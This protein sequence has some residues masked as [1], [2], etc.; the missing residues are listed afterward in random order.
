MFELNGTCYPLSLLSGSL[1]STSFVSFSSSF[2][3][4]LRSWN[5]S[6]LYLS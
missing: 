3:S 4:D 6:H 2:V 1:S 5:L